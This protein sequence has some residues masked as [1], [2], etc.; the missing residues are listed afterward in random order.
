VDVDTGVVATRTGLERGL[1]YEVT[2]DVAAAEP[3]CTD[4]PAAPLTPVDTPA[5][6][7][8][9][10]VGFTRDLTRDATTPCTRAQAIEDFLTGDGFRF[11]AEAPSGTTIARIRD[12][13]QPADDGPGL[14][15]SEQ[16]ATAFVLMAR[17]AGLPARVVVGF[18]G[19]EEAGDGTFRV[20]A[21]DAVAWGEV[22]YQGL[23]W[24]RYQPTPL[25]GED[26]PPP[27]VQEEQVESVPETESAP[28]PGPVP[29]QETDRPAPPADETPNGLAA[30]GRTAL[31]VVAAVVLVLALVLVTVAAVRGRR[32][33][34]RAGA[35]SAEGR[36]VGAWRQCLDELRDAGARPEPSDTASDVLVRSR[37][38]VGDAPTDVVVPVARMA[39]VALFGGPGL[40]DADA[41]EAWRLVEALDRET[42]ARRSAGASVRR[43][44]DVR[45]L[46][47]R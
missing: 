39:N 14:G 21:G 33:A 17:A 5:A 41:D 12:L 30:A 4:A 18:D 43:A 37:A 38:A 36:V 20:R 15:T 27:P 26:R 42:A 3:D 11:N 13:L 31:L 10:L 28:A 19:G 8:E 29:Q 9:D 44:L 24:V 35:A 25:P 2:S 1:R 32:R 46:V 6:L 34:K 47:R 16:F 40:T 7:P 45:V 22:R 23:G